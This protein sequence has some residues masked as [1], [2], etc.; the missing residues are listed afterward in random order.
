MNSMSNYEKQHLKTCKKKFFYDFKHK[1]VFSDK[2]SQNHKKAE[3][4][5][6]VKI[7][8]FCVSKDSMLKR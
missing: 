6:F 3:N 5:D 8:K 2:R 4:S 7:V 1:R